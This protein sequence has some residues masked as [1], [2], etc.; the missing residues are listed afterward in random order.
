MENARSQM[1]IL[2]SVFK[3]LGL[4]QCCK[5]APVDSFRDDEQI[6]YVWMKMLALLTKVNGYN[7]S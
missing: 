3:G 4:Q 1:Q 7:N 2:K 6:V 5:T